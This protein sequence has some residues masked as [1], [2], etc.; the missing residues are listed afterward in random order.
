[1]SKVYGL[2][3]AA[4]TAIVVAS[5]ARANE[6]VMEYVKAL[7]NATIVQAS[8]AG[9]DWRVNDKSSYKI[10]NVLLNGTSD[11]FVR[12][13]T[14]TG[15][16]LQQDMKLSMAGEQKMEI[17]LNKTTGQIEKLLVNGQEQKVPE[18][19]VEV[20][21]MKED[22]VTVAAGTFKCIYAKIKNKDD[23][24]ISQAWINPKEVPMTGQIKAIAESQLGQITQELTS[25]QFAP[26]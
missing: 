3:A 4:L 14:G 7:Q 24:K 13:D 15:Y 25:F 26:R 6:Q 17:L 1:M 10:S 19:N 8:Y 9:L 22:S 18:S 21:E 12:E 5:P 2:I 23:G 11:N 20:V 16:W